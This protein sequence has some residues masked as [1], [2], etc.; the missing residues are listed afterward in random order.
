M[1][2][3]LFPFL[4]LS[5]EKILDLFVTNDHVVQVGRF[6]F[7]SLN[8]KSIWPHFGCKQN[9]YPCPC[10]DN[11]H[12]LV[13]VFVHEGLVLQGGWVQRQVQEE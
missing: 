11:A 5:L 7:E 13:D 4:P 10:L 8:N 9:L 6:F 2:W 12:W 3:E 1:G